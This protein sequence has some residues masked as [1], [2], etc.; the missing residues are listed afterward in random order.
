MKYEHREKANV[1][2]GGFCTLHQLTVS[3]GHCQTRCTDYV[4]P[5]R[6]LGDRIEKN[7]KIATAG[8][9]KSCAGCK[10]RRIRANEWS[11]RKKT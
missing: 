6:G 2:G 1:C 7:I 3:D 10:R 4:G 8:L 9:V 5:A 11:Q